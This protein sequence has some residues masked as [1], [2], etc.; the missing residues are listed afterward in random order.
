MNIVRRELKRIFAQAR[1]VRAHRA[2]SIRAHD[3]RF[4]D[5]LRE[6]LETLPFPLL[7]RRVLCLGARQG[8]EV[9][10]FIDRGGF[11]VGIDLNP[12]E[13]NRYVLIGDFQELQFATG[14]VDIVYTN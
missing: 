4:Y 8:T 3:R 11:A 1:K 14:S 6:R 13:K 5:A 7:R 9:R 10:A 2:K 12:G